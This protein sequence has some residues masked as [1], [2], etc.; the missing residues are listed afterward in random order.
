MFFCDAFSL[1]LM[2]FVAEEQGI[3]DI[4]FPS[5]VKRRGE[6]EPEISEKEKETDV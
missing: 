2:L 5:Y 1:V 4:Q 3:I 6:T